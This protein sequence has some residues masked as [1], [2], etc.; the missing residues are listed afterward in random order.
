[1]LSGFNFEELTT[2]ERVNTAGGGFWGDI[3]DLLMENLH[4]HIFNGRSIKRYD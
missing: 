2:N 4:S 1:M 3:G